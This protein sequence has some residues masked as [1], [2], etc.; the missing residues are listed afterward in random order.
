MLI[1]QKCRII[2][3]LKDKSTSELICWTLEYFKKEKA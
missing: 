3:Y 1:I 2:S